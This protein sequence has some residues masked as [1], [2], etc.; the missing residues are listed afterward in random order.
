MRAVFRGDHQPTLAVFQFPL[1]W[2]ESLFDGSACV[3]TSD[4]ATIGQE[5]TL[6]SPDRYQLMQPEL[7]ELLAAMV[8]RHLSALHLDD[9]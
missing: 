7:V 2:A 1:A 5:P 6:K 9:R 4:R 3:L 8:G